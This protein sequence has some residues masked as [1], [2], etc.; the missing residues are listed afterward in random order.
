MKTLLKA[1]LVIALTM[2]AY[3]AVS[4]VQAS[5]GLP[6]PKYHKLLRQHGLPVKHFAYIMA[7]ESKCITRAVGWNYYKG[8]DHTNCKSG[9]FNRHKKC[10]AVK[11][12]DVGLLQVNRQHDRIVKQQCGKGTDTFIL[13]DPECNLRVAK[14]LYDLAG[15]APW[16]GT[17]H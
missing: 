13:T 8:K 17:S 9:K 12:W 3:A 7:R 2:P 10:S 6:C 14:V 4:P 16:A 11:S 5:N 1:V 15:L